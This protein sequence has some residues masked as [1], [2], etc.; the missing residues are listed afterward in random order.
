MPRI[1]SLAIEKGAFADPTPTPIPAPKS[2]RRISMAT[3]GRHLSTLDTLLKR[4]IISPEKH[5]T[6]I[7][8]LKARLG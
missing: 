2:A 1:L 5:E 4:G 7:A 8:A 3:I 6:E